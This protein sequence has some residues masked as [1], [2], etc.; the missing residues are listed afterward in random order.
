MN[1]RNCTNCYFCSEYPLLDAGGKPVIGQKIYLCKRFPPSPIL[2]PAGQPGSL[3]MIAAFPPV[4]KEISCHEHTFV[5]EFE[6][7]DDVPRGSAL[8]FDLNG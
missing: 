7:R 5:E 4:T 3:Q 1:T 8:P 2:V 6:E